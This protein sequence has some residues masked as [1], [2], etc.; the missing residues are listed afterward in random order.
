VGLVDVISH[1]DGTITIGI[2]VGH[3]VSGDIVD[4]ITSP[5]TWAIVNNGEWAITVDMTV[6][7]TVFISPRVFVVNDTLVDFTSIG[8]TIIIVITIGIE[9]INLVGI[10][11]IGI[12]D[13]TITI[14][15]IVS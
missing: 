5:H 8:I 2:I 6:I 10:D 1:V 15:I 11:V 9:F 14:G 13:N 7:W 4:I 12:V 3:V